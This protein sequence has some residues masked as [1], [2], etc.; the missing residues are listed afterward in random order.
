MFTGCFFLYCLLDSRI[1]R[2]SLLLRVD[3]VGL[4]CAN[5]PVAVR[6]T[7]PVMY[8]A[9]GAPAMSINEFSG[10]CILCIA[11]RSKWGASPW[12]Q[13][14]LSSND[15]FSSLWELGIWDMSCI[16]TTWISLKLLRFPW[17]R[18]LHEIFVCNCT[19][20]SILGLVSHRLKGWLNS[21]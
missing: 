11:D 21:A 18:H 17:S 2:Q 10:Y 1:L 19:R 3:E 4:K 8:A 6:F 15:R 7:V 5:F 20:G 14:W 9:A 12:L 13:R 16:V